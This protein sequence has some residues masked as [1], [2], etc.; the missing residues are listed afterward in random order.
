[1]GSKEAEYVWLDQAEEEIEA[2]IQRICY[3][4]GTLDNQRVRFTNDHP[5]GNQWVLW[6]KAKGYKAALKSLRI[7]DTTDNSL[8]NDRGAVVP[9]VR[10][11]FEDPDARIV[12]LEG[13]RR[14]RT[15]K[16]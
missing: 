6:M 1:M 4:K 11:F 14:V 7:G 5:T 10:E 9:L 15:C 12:L 3:A 8:M 13:F 2:L 16:H